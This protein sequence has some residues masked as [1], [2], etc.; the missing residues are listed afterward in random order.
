MEFC[1]SLSG[2][3]VLSSPR[4]ARGRGAPH[5]CSECVVLAEKTSSARAARRHALGPS[6]GFRSRQRTAL[7]TAAGAASRAAAAVAGTAAAAAGAGGSGSCAA[8]LRTAPQTTATNVPGPGLSGLEVLGG[9]LEGAGDV[10]A[11]LVRRDGAAGEEIEE[12]AG[13]SRG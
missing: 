12:G 6:V 11:V 3:P 5:T 2:Q 7:A 10:I 4:R 9:G 1:G 13:G 8:S